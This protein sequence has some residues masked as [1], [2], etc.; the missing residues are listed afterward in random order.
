E[1]RVGMV[2]AKGQSARRAA[3]LAQL[4]AGLA[5]SYLAYQLQRP[6]LNETAA[7]QRKQDFRRKQ[8]RRAREELQSLRGP[9]MKIGQ[10]ISMQS[11]FLDAAT[12]EEFSALQMHAPPMHAS[13]MRARF[14]GSLGQYPGEVFGSCEETPLTAASLGQVHRAVTNQGEEVVVKIQYPAMREAIAG[15]F[16]ALRTAG[17]AARL[18]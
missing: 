15:D 3:R 13:L 10:A 18:T 17:F 16:Q 5:G 14:K 2:K 7:K 4:G 6:F 12:I 1:R 11:H 8:A 9:I